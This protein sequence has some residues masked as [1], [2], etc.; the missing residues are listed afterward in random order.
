MRCLLRITLAL[1]VALALTSCDTTQPLQVGSQTLTLVTSSAGGRVL[2]FD[3]WEGFEDTLDGD[4]EP[5]PGTETFL[6]CL[7]VFGGGAEPER[8]DVSPTSIPWA[9][10]IEVRRIP[11]GETTSELVSLPESAELTANLTVYDETL[12]QPAFPPLPE[13]VEQNRTFKFRAPRRV[14]ALNREVVA[15]TSN[16]LST[17][18]PAAYEVG[19]GLCSRSDP[20]LPVVDGGTPPLDVEVGKGDSILVTVTRG[21]LLDGQFLDHNDEPMITLFPSGITT[22][23]RLDDVPV[24]PQG[25]ST[26]GADEGDSA[27]FSYTSR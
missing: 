18:N 11:A 24:T 15:A 9:F 6:W 21:P 8:L 20:G 7:Y 23:V 3:V 27:S 2:L 5:D 25:N 4:D 1:T 10:G 12:Q 19:S 14:T 13:I 22:T 26:T 17:L 16:T